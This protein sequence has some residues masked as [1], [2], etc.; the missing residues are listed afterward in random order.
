MTA[1]GKTL[2]FFNL[3]FSLVT[4]GLIVMVFVTRTNWREGMEKA[5]A[6]TR[7]AQA[8][9]KAIKTQQEALKGDAENARQKLER[10][11]EGLNKDIAERQAEISNQKAQADAAK[12]DA[13]EH[14]AVSQTQSIEIGR[15]QKER[16]QMAE[17]LKAANDSIAKI[18]KDLADMTQQEKYHHL[19]GD[20]LEK[21]LSET[22]ELASQLR[23]KVE[24]LT[25]RTRNLPAIGAQANPP[26]VPSF[27]M[28][29]RVLSAEG[30]WAVISLGSDNGIEQGHLLQVYRTSP[31]P[32]YLG[33]LTIT[34]AEPHQ[35]VGNFEPA[36]KGRKIQAND[37]VDTRIQR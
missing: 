18:T 35:A 32:V 20:A 15:L 19:R 26:K 34:K 22:R 29:G 21:E 37:T 12:K 11:I 33:T 2:V 17:Y 13:N 1:L 6:E 31:Q 4:G 30:N 36:A 14:L 24:E 5:M 3:L 10:Q 27:D 7:A 25:A 8:E 28:A 9:V 16:N 23:R